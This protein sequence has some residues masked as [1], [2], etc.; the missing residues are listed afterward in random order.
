MTPLLQPYSITVRWRELDLLPSDDH[1]R[2]PQPETHD[3]WI[4]R[5]RGMLQAALD[6]DAR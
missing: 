2:E 4:E 6:A 5:L 1:L 3:E